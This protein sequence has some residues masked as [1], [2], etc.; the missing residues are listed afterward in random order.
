MDLDSIVTRA[1]GLWSSDL[2]L[3]LVVLV[4][5]RTIASLSDNLECQIDAATDSE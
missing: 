4:H 2:P 3:V 1:Y 5:C